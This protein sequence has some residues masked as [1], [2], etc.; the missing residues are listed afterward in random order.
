MMG[1]L[2]SIFNRDRMY[3]DDFIEQLKAYIRLN[4]QVAGMGSFIQR[5]AFALTLIQG[6]LVAEWT[7]AM[8]AWL[9]TLQAIDDIP[10]V[11]DQ[12]LTEFSNQYQDTQRQQRAR[13]ELKALQLKWPDI[14]QYANNFEHLMQVA[15]YNL[16]NPETI[17]HRLSGTG[18]GTPVGPR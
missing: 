10:A 17:C 4:R 6:P 1:A 14:D 9:D 18:L 5:V 13:A 15:G 7:R 16:A 12:F 8:G 11:W 2:P 3:A